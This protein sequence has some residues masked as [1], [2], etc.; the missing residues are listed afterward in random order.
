MKIKGYSITVEFVIGL[1]SVVLNAFL[2]LFV[3]ITFPK[4]DP[5]AILHYTAGV[6]I[7]FVGSPLQIFVLPGIGLAVLLINAVLARFVRS[8]SHVAFWIFWASLPILECMLIG[9]YAI[10]LRLNS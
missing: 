1:V 10:L 8:V 5:S 2:W 4:H 9:T 7:D 6:G 3:L